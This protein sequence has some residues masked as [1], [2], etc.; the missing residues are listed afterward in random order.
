MT[1]CLSECLGGWSDKTITLGRIESLMSRGAAF[2]PVMDKWLRAGLWVV[3]RSDPDYPKRLKQRLGVDAPAA[4]F[5][6]GDKALLNLGGLAVAGSRN[7]VDTDLIYARELGALAAADDCLV[8][9][10]GARGIDE[11]AM[12]GALEAGGMVVGVMVSNLLQA[13]SSVK[14]R[15]YVMADNLALISPFCPDARFSIGNAMQRNKYIYCLSDVAA[16]AHSGSTGGT[17]NGAMEN[18]KKRW[19]PLWVKRTT[20]EDAGNADIVKAGGTWM[21]DNVREIDFK[22]LFSADMRTKSSGGDLFGSVTG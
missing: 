12:L 17:W 7:A 8:V 13:C 19:V 1:E 15:D 3:T 16:V 21:S 18:L 14:Y 20:D 10:G 4:L 22:A 11:A 5:G 2:G 6:C 9:S